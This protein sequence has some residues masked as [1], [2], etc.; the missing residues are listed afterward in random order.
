[1]P[2]L[3]PE[4]G[5]GRMFWADNPG[6]MGPPKKGGEILGP[7]RLLLSPI[8]PL[9]S[10]SM[11]H[12]L[13]ASILR[14]GLVRWCSGIKEGGRENRNKKL[15]SRR[16]GLFGPRGGGENPPRVCPGTPLPR[17]TKAYLFPRRKLTGG[18]GTRVPSPLPGPAQAI[19][20][21]GPF[22]REGPVVLTL[23]VPPQN[24]LLCTIR[25]AFGAS[26]SPTGK[27]SG[28]GPLFGLPQ[29]HPP[30]PTCRAR[31]APTP[32]PTAR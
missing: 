5:L 10:S 29:K 12:A 14:F 13:G 11:L 24:T 19:P 20:S 3:S 27:I 9:I 7:P 8:L 2:G 16:R 30:H 1:L 31:A 26:N 4:K 32:P 22:L 6:G 17:T 15:W 21:G 23:L 28:G 25:G 18:G